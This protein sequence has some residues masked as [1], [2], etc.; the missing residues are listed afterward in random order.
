MV[1]R[2]GRTTAAPRGPAGDRMSETNV[3]P[4]DVPVV[5]TELPGPQEP[6]AV[7]PSRPRPHGHARSPRGAVR[8]GPQGRLDD[9]GCGRQHVRRPLLGL[10]L[11]AARRHARGGAASR[12]RGPAPVRHGDQ[13]LRRH[14][15]GRGARRAIGGDRA[16][17][18]HEDLDGGQRH[19]G[20]GSRREAGARS[21]RTSHDPVVLRPVPRRV[22]LPHRRHVHRSVRG[23]H[24]TRPVRRGP[25]VRALP[26]PVPGS[27]SIQA[28]APSTT[29]GTSTTS[30]NGSWSTRWSRR[31]SPAS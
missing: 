14:R 6:S 22:H 5:R 20:R 1:R 30:K 11:D 27:R 28:Q 8:R 31:R 7:R 21:H 24:P 9:R 15:T 2:R 4:P 18:A 16:T 29:S 26:Q 17:R 19:P 12:D 3:A 23:P 13:Q 25:R 10:G